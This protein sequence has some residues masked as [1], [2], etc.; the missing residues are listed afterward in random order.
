MDAEKLDPQKTLRRDAP[1]YHYVCA[2]CY[3]HSPE[4]CGRDAEDI[5]VAPDGRFLCDDCFQEEHCDTEW[6]SAENPLE[7]DES[8]A[9]AFER[10]RIARPEVAHL[11]MTKPQAMTPQWDRSWWLRSRRRRT[12]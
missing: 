11:T 3:E 1:K 12:S 10:G 2:S 8:I 7:I 4:Q 9:A 6:W 5:R